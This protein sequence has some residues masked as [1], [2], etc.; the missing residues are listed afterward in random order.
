MI[1]ALLGVLV[2]AIALYLQHIGQRDKINC[3]QGWL[4]STEHPAS[5]VNFECYFSQSYFE[6]KF[7]FLR[8][9]EIAGAEVLNLPVLGLYSSD[10]AILRGDPERVLIHIS[11][12]HGLL[13]F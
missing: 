4:L 8:S 5:P 2:V 7:K 6:A 10:V 12:T 1:T 11:A 9:A 13:Q 3:P